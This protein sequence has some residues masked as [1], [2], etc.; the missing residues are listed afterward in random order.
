MSYFTAI[1]NNKPT[2][3]FNPFA[4]TIPMGPT[5]T[6]PII[7]QPIDYRDETNPYIA[8]CHELS[9]KGYNDG[10]KLPIIDMSQRW[11]PVTCYSILPNKYYI[12]DK[13]NMYSTNIDAWL[14]ERTTTHVHNRFNVRVDYQEASKDIRI[15]KIMMQT[16]YP[17]PDNVDPDSVEVEHINGN[18]KDNRLENLRWAPINVPQPVEEVVEV[19]N[20][21]T[22]SIEGINES[23][24]QIIDV[25]RLMEI[26]VP[27]EL[28][29]ETIFHKPL[30]KKIKQLFNNIIR[31]VNHIDISRDFNLDFK[32]PDLDSDSKLLTKE[33]KK[34]VLDL[35]RENADMKAY[36]KSLFY[37]NI[38]FKIGIKP[39]NKK[40]RASYTNAIRNLIN[41]F[42]PEIG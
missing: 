36:N 30:D 32:F 25:C 11:M 13:G 17:L 15:D 14:K 20:T 18:Y 1:P 22:H 37:D 38:L 26:N 23:D 40:E 4:G 7:P 9:R 16:Y 10:R 3:D 21:E 29:S 34:M 6:A 31:G 39:S 33:Q 27:W 5:N 8:H 41:Q 42:C 19:N 24:Q 35:A 2:N 12:S 28:I